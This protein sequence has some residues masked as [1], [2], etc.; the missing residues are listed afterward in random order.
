MALKSQERNR[1]G[2]DTTMLYLSIAQAV[3]YAVLSQGTAPPTFPSDFYT[4]MQTSLVI[5]QGG[6]DIDSGACCAQTASQCKVQGVAMGEDM[7]QQGSM[8]RSRT[9]VH[10]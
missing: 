6:Y 1:R 2:R 9:D 5:N 3:S 4:G 7:R 10:A 8:N